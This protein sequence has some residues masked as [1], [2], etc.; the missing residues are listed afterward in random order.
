MDKKIQDKENR[1]ERFEMVDQLIGDQDRLKDQIDEFEQPF[2]SGFSLK[3]D[4]NT[5]LND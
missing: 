5:K 3:P 4:E 2:V 1:V